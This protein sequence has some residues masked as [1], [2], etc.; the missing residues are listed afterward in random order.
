LDSAANIVEAAKPSGSDNKKKILAVLGIL[1]ALFGVGAGAYLIRNRQL[2]ES[3]AWD[4]SLYTFAVSDNGTVTVANGSSRSEPPQQAQVYINGSLVDTFEVP[5][6]A[7]GEGETLGTVSVPT[8]ETYTWRVDGTRDCDD[9]GTREINQVTASCGQVVAY[10]ESWTELGS[11][12]LS[13]LSEGDMVRFAVKGTASSGTFEMARFS[14]NGG[15]AVEV[16]DKR[17]GSDDFYYEYTIP[18]DV[19]EFN[20]NAEVFHSELGWF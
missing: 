11:G 5:A 16:T 6:L 17:P 1:L 13:Q 18:A 14:V 2:L 3:S 15:I 12:E 4:C 20:V 19:T 9:S 7:P 8:N 10:D